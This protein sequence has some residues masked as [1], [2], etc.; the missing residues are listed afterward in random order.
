MAIVWIIHLCITTDIIIVTTTTIVI[1]VIIILI[2][3]LQ[4]IFLNKEQTGL[5]FNI[6]FCWCSAPVMTLYCK[7][8]WPLTLGDYT[9]LWQTIKSKKVSC[10]WEGRGAEARRFP[11]S[12]LGKQLSDPRGSGGA[13]GCWLNLSSTRALCRWLL[14]TTFGNRVIYTLLMFYK[15]SFCPKITISGLNQ[16]L[17]VL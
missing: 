12:L 17:W 4:K 8:D 6:R 7:S 13:M 5:F 16:H 3:V 14:L 10:T 15:S 1:V 2:V 9:S 11:G